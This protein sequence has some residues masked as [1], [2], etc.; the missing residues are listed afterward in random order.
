MHVVRE[1]EGGAF[2]STN[3]PKARNTAPMATLIFTLL[4]ISLAPRALKQA[5]EESSTTWQESS[6]TIILSSGALAAR[7]LW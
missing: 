6:T 5:S 2:L 1:V 7:R 3:H 4:I